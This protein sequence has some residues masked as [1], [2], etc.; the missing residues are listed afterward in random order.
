MEQIR[1]Q[2][3][4]IQELKLELFQEIALLSRIPVVLIMVFRDTIL[5]FPNGLVFALFKG[6]EKNK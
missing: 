3:R 4:I 1:A 5:L 6:V 2:K